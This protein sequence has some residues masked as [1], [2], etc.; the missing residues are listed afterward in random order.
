MKAMHPLKGVGVVGGVARGKAMVSA[1]GIAFNLGVDETTGI[2]IEAGHELERQC[3][4]GRVLVFPGGKG[5]SAGSFSLLQLASRGLAPCAIVNVQT[6]AV[7]AAGAVLAKVPLVH[8]LVVDPLTEIHDGD[9]IEVNG[10]DGT[11]TLVG[12]V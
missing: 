4:A 12:A 5:S 9:L 1:T 7:V 10:D 6:D 2:V 3:I 11:V 8:R